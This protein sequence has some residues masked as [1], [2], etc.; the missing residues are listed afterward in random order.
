MSHGSYCSSF[1][2]GFYVNL[3]AFICLGRTDLAESV[4]RT[5]LL[6]WCPVPLVSWA[7]PIFLFSEFNNEAC[8]ACHLKFQPSSHTGIQASPWPSCTSD[9]TLPGT[10]STSTVVSSALGSHRKEGHLYMNCY[11]WRVSYWRLSVLSDRVINQ[12]KSEM[13][14]HQQQ[15]FTINGL[16][17]T[18]HADKQ[19]PY[20][21]SQSII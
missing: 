11:Y 21:K 20:R 6:S 2:P 3:T 14:G 4:D 10:G 16:S 12:H 15:Y 9:N 8:C 17:F 7:V 18:E 1:C 19:F 5:K 13:H